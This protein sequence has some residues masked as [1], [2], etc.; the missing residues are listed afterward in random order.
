MARDPQGR[1]FQP[2]FDP[3]IE[4]SGVPVRQYQFVQVAPAALELAYV[5]ERDMSE[6]E[7]ARLNEAV[8]AQMGYAVTLSV[9]RVDAIPRSAGG[10]F[11]GF[12]SR[13]AG[14]AG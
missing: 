3:A 11:E 5:M 9:R 12:V 7:R 14:Q 8:S 10:K 1:L 2:A 4:D 6:E 13:V